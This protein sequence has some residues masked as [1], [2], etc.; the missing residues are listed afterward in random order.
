MKIF[1]NYLLGEFI[2]VDDGYENI[3]TPAKFGLGAAG[4]GAAGVVF[5]MVYG[6][7][8]NIPE[9]AG[10]SQLLPPTHIQPGP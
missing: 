5:W 10:Q 9:N 1:F 7:P 8:G 6:I 2:G 3:A 4:A